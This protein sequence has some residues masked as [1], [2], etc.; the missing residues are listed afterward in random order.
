M[1]TYYLYL[2]LLLHLKTFPL[3][4]QIYCITKFLLNLLN[5]TF[6]CEICYYL[7]YFVQNELKDFFLIMNV[8]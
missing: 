7:F 4:I 3:I 2:L 1:F 6:Y 8:M 5:V